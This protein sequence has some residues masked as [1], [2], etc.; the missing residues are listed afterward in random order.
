ML[1]RCMLA[2]AALSFPGL[3][4]AGSAETVGIAFAQSASATLWCRD[5]SPDRAI[6]C[7]LEK[8]RREAA[9]ETCHATRWCAPAGWSGAMV[10]WLP[11]FHATLIVC[12]A[13]GEAAVLAALK[14][15][16]D[17]SEEFTR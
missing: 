4:V 16:C 5:A 9:A 2:L 7:A 3:A 1:L 11:E 10:T 6:D 12:G 8:C 17:N 14:A 15:L 13:S